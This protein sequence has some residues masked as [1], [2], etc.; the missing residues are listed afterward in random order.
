MAR[1]HARQSLLKAFERSLLHGKDMTW[2]Y[3]LAA[4][5]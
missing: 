4:L 2:Q 3:D 5:W 1:W